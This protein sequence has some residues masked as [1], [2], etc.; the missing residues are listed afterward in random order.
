LRKVDVPVP[1]AILQS[2]PGTSGDAM[3]VLAGVIFS[4][5]LLGG[6]QLIPMSVLLLIARLNLKKSVRFPGLNGNG[7]SDAAPAD[8][9]I[10]FAEI[11][12]ELAPIKQLISEG[13]DEE[14]VEALWERLNKHMDLGSPIETQALLGDMLES[15]LKRL[16]EEAHALRIHELISN[17]KTKLATK[18]LAGGDESLFV[19]ALRDDRDLTIR[20]LETLEAIQGIQRP[21]ASAFAWSFYWKAAVAYAAA[22]ALASIVVL[23]AN[24]YNRT[25]GRVQDG[26]VLSTIIG[27]VAALLA[28]AHQYY[29]ART[30]TYE[31]RSGSLRFQHGGFFRKTP[32][33]ELYR[34]HTVTTRQSLI[35]RFSGD[36]T[37]S[38][39]FDKDQH[40]IVLRGWVKVNEMDRLATALRE[41]SRALRTSAAIKGIL[42]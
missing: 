34:L 41:V 27:I 10:D 19:M 32:I 18:S 29:V 42:T 20:T 9:K 12:K 38:L 2:A 11:S 1:V 3:N 37:F 28:I 31:L 21:F 30:T 40:P 14:V 8:R 4:I 5:F 26:L 7:P 22:S 24:P 13:K 39:E 23:G 35:N 33:H 16:G 17:Q 15:S 36:C 6:F 25:P